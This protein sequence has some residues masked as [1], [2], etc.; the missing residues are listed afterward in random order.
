MGS[1]NNS[2]VDF[3]I[4]GTMMPSNISNE[5]HRRV[6][7]AVDDWGAVKVD[8]IAAPA[9]VETTEVSSRWYTKNDLNL[10]RDELRYISRSVREH[11]THGLDKKDTYT[12]VINRTLECCCSADNLIPNNRHL[13]TFAQWVKA[14]PSRR[15]LEWKCI[16]RLEKER[17]RRIKD[18]VDGVVRLYQANKDVL[19]PSMLEET[20]RQ[21]AEAISQPSRMFARCFGFADEIATIDSESHKSF[22]AITREL[23]T[24]QN[25]RIFKTS[26]K[27]Q[28]RLVK[29]MSIVPCSMH[30]K[31]LVVQ[32]CLPPSSVLT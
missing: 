31:E 7:I 18:H 14:A 23:V 17:L 2:S 13:N 6:T 21:R 32:R 30:R 15:G 5:E 10:I 27:V 25:T 4:D 8:I 22:Y 16:P 11:H 9:V 1:Q 12:N 29:S 24:P 28:E 20:L 3:D 19:E 26:T